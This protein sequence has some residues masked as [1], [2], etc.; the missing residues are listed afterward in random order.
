M[1]GVGV[2]AGVAV[3][4]GVGVAVTVGVALA[5]AVTL[6]VAVGG[7]AV[8]VGAAAVWVSRSATWDATGSL[9]GVAPWQAARAAQIA[10]AP[11]RLKARQVRVTPV[12]GQYLSDE[13]GIW[14]GIAD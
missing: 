4:T 10:R 7:G 3:S 11:Q 14:G 2:S 8:A 12:T 13:D 1:V 9:A 5:V 6:G